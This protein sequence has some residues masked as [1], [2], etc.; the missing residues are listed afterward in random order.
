MIGCLETCF[1]IEI[2]PNVR[3][4]GKDGCCLCRVEVL[5]VIIGIVN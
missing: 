4:R 5:P 2:V 1:G 3:V